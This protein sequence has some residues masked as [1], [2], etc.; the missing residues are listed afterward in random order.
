MNKLSI[1]KLVL[2]VSALA[3]TSVFSACTDSF[4]KWNTNPN[5]ATEEQM[6]YD[7]LKVGGFFSQMQKGVFIVGD[8]KS[9]EYQITQALAG[10]LFAGYLATITSWSYT[11]YNNDH[12]ALYPNWYN[13]AFNDAYTDIMQP[14]KSL[15]ENTED[16]SVARAMGTVVRVL[17]MSRITD[18][19]GP[20][21]YSKFGTGTQVAYDSQ[22]DVYASFFN[23]LDESIT[24][25]S[26]FS[27]S[28]SD[29]VMAKYDYIY[30]G[31]VA[32]WLKFANT[33][34]LRLAMRVSNVNEAK[35]REEIA[36]CVDLG[37]FIETVDDAAYLH[38]GTYLTFINPFYEITV[39]WNDE[40]MSATMDCYL[41]GLA[42]PRVSAYYV[43][44]AD[45]AYHGV[46]NG[47]PSVNK[48]NYIN[49]ASS[50]NSN[51]NDGMKW[52]DAAETNFLLAEAKLRFDLGTKS[53]R[54]YYEA[55]IKASF[56]YWG[57]GGADAYIADTEKRA[58]DTYT[59]PYNSRATSVTSMLTYTSICWEDGNDSENL[60][61]I[62]LQKWIALFPD[63]QEAWSDMR[64]TGLP[65]WV[66]IY[67][68]GY[69]T[70]VANNE[71]I[72]RLR[73]PTTEYSNN[74]ANTQA[75]V[76]LLGGIDTAGTRL[77]W[78]VKR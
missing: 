76:A 51:S 58:L 61:K 37:Q 30:S 14:Y 2:G 25:L 3:A 16:G 18:M 23:E 10:D 46:R 53:A 35:A 31:N 34:R 6:G 49:N 1:Y 66:R 20:I 56:D 71:L 65:G 9:A 72:S 63:G 22:A 64:R 48:D 17:G 13:A 77:W 32:K 38:Q 57:V 50:M 4:E 45:G 43:P 24:V 68:Y 21:P 15:Y 19:F 60:K 27:K 28:S 59:D 69:Q 52:M 62:A 70:D 39:S 75:A 8:N 55:G 36:K 5:E 26:D 78:D 67:N 41:N 29:R 47:M 40:K 74:T 12:Y 33:L 7:N 73:F 42:D 44:A 54:E 11:N